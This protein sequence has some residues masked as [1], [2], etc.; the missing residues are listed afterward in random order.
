MSVWTD[1][2]PCDILY[3]EGQRSFLAASFSLRDAAAEEWIDDVAFVGCME[4]FRA[5]FTTAEERADPDRLYDLFEGDP[6]WEGW[7]TTVLP[8]PCRPDD[9]GAHLYWRVE[10][11]YDR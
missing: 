9:D 6:E 11:A 4:W 5:R 3:C 10:E 7:D 1:C 8:S 2:P